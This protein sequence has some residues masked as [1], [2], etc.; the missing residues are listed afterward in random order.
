MKTTRITNKFK[1]MLLGGWRQGANTPI[2][3]DTPRLDGKIVAITG[4]NRGIGYETVKGLSERGAEVIVLSRNL[5]KTEATVRELP[6]TVH[7]VKLDLEDILQIPSAVREI[8]KILNGRYI[9]IL[10]N[11]AGIAVKGPCQVSPQGFEKTFAVNVLGHHILFRLCHQRGLLADSAKIISVTGDIYIQADDCTVD[12]KYRGTSGMAAYSRS[13]IGLMWWAY[14]CLD[15][16]PN[17]QVN[18]VHPGIVPSGLGNDENSLLVKIMGKLFV[19]S[20]LG[21]QMSL[22]CATQEDIENGAYYHNTLGKMI[23]PKD[24]VA[25][26]Q[27][28]ALKMWNELEQIFDS[29]II[30][31]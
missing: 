3:P 14:Q 13:K 5:K 8:N 19:T 24:D 26:D 28:R 6:S 27:K 25:L 7:S 12:Y 10:I 18:L 22:I 31:Y 1:R 16:H 17:Y 30:A 20:K 21:A 2:C 23:L 11:N 9:D 4:G 15:H 29:Y